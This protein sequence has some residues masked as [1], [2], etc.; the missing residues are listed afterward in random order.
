MSTAELA[1]LISIVSATF[2]GSGLIWQLLLYRLSGARLK[3]RLMPANLDIS[4]DILHGPE[5]GW[6]KGSI[7]EE[8]SP[9]SPWR[10][11]LAEV[12]VTNVGRA[13]ISVSDI[14][15][16]F[17]H[18]YSWK[19]GRHTI[20]G[21][22]IAAQDSFT[23]DTVRLEAGATITVFFDLW[24]VVAHAGRQ[25]GMEALAVRASARPAGRRPT[26]SSW[27]KRWTMQIGR[28]TFI[29][30]E[31]ASPSTRAY[32]AL[33][34]GLQH[35]EE[36]RGLISAAW[37][38]LQSILERSPSEVEVR[39]SLESTLG[40]GKAVLALDIVEAYKADINQA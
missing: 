27:R 34:R 38:P 32:N 1:V 21:T 10:V 39:K 19:F 16:D 9:S 30:G 37:Y 35:S 31:L 3:V 14:C 22:P 33:W 2:T 8:L 40:L 18:F 29:C 7:P 24:R 28:G 17:G 13:A 26:R 11:E 6:K 12:R 20:R 23:D 25:R 5:D 36:A 4:G 15:L